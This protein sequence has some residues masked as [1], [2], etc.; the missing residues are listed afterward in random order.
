MPS[1]IFVLVFAV[2]WTIAVGLEAGLVW[3][4][5]GGLALDVLAPAAAR[6]VRLRARALSSVSPR[7]SLASSHGFGHSWSLPL[8]GLLSLVYSM[9]LFILLGALGS[10]AVDSTDPV[11]IA[12]CPASSTTRWS[13]VLV[14]PLAVAIHDR[15]VGEERV[16]W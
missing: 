7:R 1:R 5:V 16:D 15:H 13:A 14:G 12:D 3:A 8:V 11:A 2:I 4:F 6:R 10:S 9:T